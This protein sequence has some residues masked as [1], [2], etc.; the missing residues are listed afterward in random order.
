MVEQ[1]FILHNDP[2]FIKRLG[3]PL[4]RHNI[5]SSI[6]KEM[7]IF[8]NI[9]GMSFLGSLERG[10]NYH[11][12]CRQQPYFRIYDGDETRFLD[13]PSM[14]GT[15]SLG[16]NLA[17]NAWQKI[18]QSSLQFTG[19]KKNYPDYLQQVWEL[20][21]YLRD[22]KDIYQQMPVAIVKEILSD[23][24]IIESPFCTFPTKDLEEPKRQIKELMVRYGDYPEAI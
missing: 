4:K 14:S 15:V 17:P 8:E 23:M 12:A 24:E 20:G 6:L 21:Q 19:D 1:P 13:H 16:A 9:V 2:E 18:T 7:S 22:L 11:R 5:R 10:H 3:R